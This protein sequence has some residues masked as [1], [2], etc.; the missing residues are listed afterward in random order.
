MHLNEDIPVPIIVKDIGVGNF[1]LA[2][3][4]STVVTLSNELL[5][6]VR[7]LRVLVEVLHVRMS[8]GRIQVVIDFLDV[9]SVVSWGEW[10]GVKST[11]AQGERGETT[12]DLDDQ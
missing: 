7:S 10:I 5:V 2:N 9:L 6:R 11:F 3:V 1:K 12:T 4:P 8:R